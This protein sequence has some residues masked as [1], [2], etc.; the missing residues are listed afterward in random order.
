MTTA[1]VPHRQSRTTSSHNHKRRKR[2]APA[3][4]PARRYAL[5]IGKHLSLALTAAKY[6]FELG[7]DGDPAEDAKPGGDQ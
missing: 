3:K 6:D 5:D 2:K 1:I 4:H 7:D